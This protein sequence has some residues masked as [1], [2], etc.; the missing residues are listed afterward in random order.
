MLMEM[1]DCLPPQTAVGSVV[2]STGF[3]F[4]AMQ[5]LPQDTPLFGFQR[6]PFISRTIEYGR[7]ARLMGYKES[8]SMAVERCD[9]PEALR[10]SMEQLLAT[11]VHLLNS[12]YEV[13]LSNSN[14]LLHPARLYSLWNEWNTDVVYPR[15]PLFYEEWTVEAAELYIV[16]DQELQQLLDCLPVGKGSIPTVLDYYEC[17]DAV[18]LAEKLR[19]IEAFKGIVAPMKAVGGGFIPDFQSRYFVE[20]FPYGLSI[21]E[22]LARKN[23]IATPIISKVCQWGMSVINQKS[24]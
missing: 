10:R 16:M 8:L 22:R 1:K 9:N 14:P 11:P 24:A 13:S 17:T 21:V 20:D 19:S 5:L 2:S 7:R 15:I 12:Y 3:F 6:V 4:E 23:S 18:S